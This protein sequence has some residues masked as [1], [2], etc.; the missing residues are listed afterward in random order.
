MIH[1]IHIQR[2]IGNLTIMWVNIY[3]YIIGESN[4]PLQEGWE[5]SC[6]VSN[7]KTQLA[8]VLAYDY[9]KQDSLMTCIRKIYDYEKVFNH[10][11][12]CK[13]N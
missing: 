2:G 5:G 11:Y 12:N 1:V 9:E 8:C 6:V 7:G 3:I 10:H 13:K 4:G